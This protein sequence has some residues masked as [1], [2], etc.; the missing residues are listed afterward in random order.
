MSHLWYRSR[1]FDCNT[2]GLHQALRSIVYVSLF[3]ARWYAVIGAFR[4]S[5]LFRSLDGVPSGR[6]SLIWIASLTLRVYQW[7]SRSINLTLL[8]IGICSVSLACSETAEVWVRANR[9]SPSC[10]FYQFSHWSPSFTNIH[11][12]TFVWD[13][14]ND[15]VLFWWFQGVFSSY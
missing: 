13:L 14:L 12:A 8:Q 4:Y 3:V 9:M 5:L 2:A 11:F 7:G 6:W 10:S 1:R 15:T